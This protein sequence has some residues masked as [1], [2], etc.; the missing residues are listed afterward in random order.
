MLGFEPWL[1]L[2]LTTALAQWVLALRG[3]P[4]SWVVLL[5]VPAVL[6]V[7]F[8][9]LIA[10]SLNTLLGQLASI[11]PLIAVLLSVEAVLLWRLRRP[12]ILLSP[13]PFAA[14]LLAQLLVLQK[15]WLLLEFA[16][17]VAVT[18]GL[19]LLLM[20]AMI[21]VMPRRSAHFAVQMLMWL[22]ILLGWLAASDWP[23]AESTLMGTDWGALVAA[24]GMLA[25]PLVLGLLASLL[26]PNRE[27]KIFRR[28]RC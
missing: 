10:A 22:Q 9:Q 8:S 26:P 25:I 18:G 11:E 1:A 5:L 16:T 21:Y 7:S 24:L 3:Q 17:S 6:W 14:L 12:W 13:G 19:I 2:A 27:M 28:G 4:Y 23:R 20:V 15:G